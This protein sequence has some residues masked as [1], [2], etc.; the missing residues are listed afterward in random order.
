MSIGVDEAGRGSWA[1]PIVVGIVNYGRQTI[2]GI[3]DSKMIQEKK[4]E[5]IFDKIT[6]LCP[7]SIGAASNAEIDSLGIIKAENL[8][9]N[10]A[11]ENFSSKIKFLVIDGRDKW[12]LSI[13]Y[14]TITKGD[15]T[16]PSISAASI[17]AKVWRDR[18]M[19][20]ISLM[21]PAYLFEK[22]KG[23]GTK[24]HRESLKK[25]GVC[26]INRKSYRPIQNIISRLNRKKRILLHACCA[27]CASGTIDR[28][29]ND[30]YEVT[31][32]F[33]DPNIL[34]VS[35]YK[36]RLNE[37]RKLSEI[38]KISF[39]EGE[40]KN[41]LWDK[42]TERFKN[43][44][45]LG[46]RCTICYQMRL[47]ETAQRAKELGF[48]YFTTTLTI[49]P[50]KDSERIKNLGGSIGKRFGV[51]FLYYDFKKKDGFLKSVQNSREYGFY[52]QDF[53]GCI[54]SRR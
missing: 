47:A 38:Y 39:I 34:P 40:Y 44:P 10:R 12:N 30:G 9:I 13:P 32:F 48:D 17:V 14:K 51:N 22:N 6:G 5:Q 52:R 49:S 26:L 21:Y 46:K 8:A 11:I 25:F 43:E 41:L 4:R 53:C 50:H 54:Y 27:P 28:L 45:E 7:Y 1:G 29:K 37:A 23:Y 2:D 35:E 15:I 42:L 19:K 3:A 31:L 36:R 20:L 16:V 33:Y 18:Y 24:A